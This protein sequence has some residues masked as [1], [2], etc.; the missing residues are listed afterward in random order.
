MY[1]NGY[2]K[3]FIVHIKT[4]LRGMLLCNANDLINYVLS[5]FQTGLFA[6]KTMKRGRSIIFSTA[7]PTEE[8]KPRNGNSI[9][10]VV[11][12]Y[13]EIQPPSYER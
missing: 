6:R 2:N 8:N 4:T 13:R 1:K 11:Q 7:D 3:I 5:S 12:K 9:L 10:C